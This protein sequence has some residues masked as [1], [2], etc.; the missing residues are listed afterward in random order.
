MCTFF[1]FGTI[2][3][4]DVGSRERQ[5]SQSSSGIVCGLGRNWVG[6]ETASIQL[7]SQTHKARTHEYISRLVV[8]SLRF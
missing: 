6:I 1:C 7:D 4:L 8:V 5:R 2:G 3:M